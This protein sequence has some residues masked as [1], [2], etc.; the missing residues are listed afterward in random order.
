MWVFS[1]RRLGKNKW[2]VVGAFAKFVL[3][4]TTLS[5]CLNCQRYVWQGLW[6]CILTSMIQ[7]LHNTKLNVWPFHTVNLA[8]NNIGPE[9]A[10]VLA[11]SSSWTLL[12]TL[13]LDL[14]SIEIEGAAVLAQSLFWTSL[15]TLTLGYN[16]MGVKGAVELAK[17]SSWTMLHTLNAGTKMA[18]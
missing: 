15:S 11:Q 5:I 10:A 14:N 12:H 8:G 18:R 16:K 4:Y 17:N 13:I 9:G 2:R 6:A 1:T 7:A 3:L